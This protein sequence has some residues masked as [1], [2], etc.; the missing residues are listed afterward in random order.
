MRIPLL[1]RSNVP[2]V[3]FSWQ[4]YNFGKCFVYKNGMPL[5]QCAL[6]ITNEDA[7]PISLYC[8]YQSTPQLKH[9][10]EPTVLQQRKSVTTQFTFFARKAG[11]FAEHVEFEI[12]SLSRQKVDVLAEGVEMKVLYS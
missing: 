11:P 1:G 3:S 6:T 9:T 12:N 10:F 7:K 5:Q 2:A 8:L 4:Q